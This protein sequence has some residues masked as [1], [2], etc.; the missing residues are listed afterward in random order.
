VV[1]ELE[2]GVSFE[3][4]SRFIR[5][6][7]FDESPSDDDLLRIFN[8]FDKVWEHISDIINF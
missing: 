7:I 1:S 4:F 5:S 8:V 6:L 3:E 2:S